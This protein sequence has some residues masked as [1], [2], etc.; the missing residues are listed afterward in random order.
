MLK[1]PMFVWWYHL[2][3]IYRNCM[4]EKTSSYVS[5]GWYHGRRH[6]QGYGYRVSTY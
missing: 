6:C 4:Q 1:N 5:V 3:N 2:F